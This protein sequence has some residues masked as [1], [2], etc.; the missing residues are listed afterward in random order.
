MSNSQP[1][2]RAFPKLVKRLPNAM[3]SR[4]ASRF[5]VTGISDALCLGSRRAPQPL[6]RLRPPSMVGTRL[7]DIDFSLRF[8][9]IILVLNESAL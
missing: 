9:M 5:P 2:S 3:S 6:V 8:A 1:L 4:V 7:L